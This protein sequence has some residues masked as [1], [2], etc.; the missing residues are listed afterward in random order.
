MGSPL[1]LNTLSFIKLCLN[2]DGG[3]PCEPRN[4]YGNYVALGGRDWQERKADRSPPKE[5]IDFFQRSMQS[6]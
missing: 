5:K 3:Y 1:G 4:C 2:Q 6:V